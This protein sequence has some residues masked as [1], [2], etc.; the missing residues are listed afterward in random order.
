MTKY[1][2]AGIAQV[3]LDTQWLIAGETTIV[4]AAAPAENS[5]ESQSAENPPQKIS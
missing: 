2:G 5:V 1:G 4:F 3:E